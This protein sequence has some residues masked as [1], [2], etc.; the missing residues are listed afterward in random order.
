MSTKNYPTQV[1][2]PFGEALWAHL[3]EADK[4]FSELGDF[5]VN[6]KISEEDASAL[7]RQIQEEKE[8]A[9]ITFKEEAKSE[10]KTA[11][12]IDK[13]KL[14]DI[15]PYEEDDEEE[16]VYIFKFK[17]KAAYVKDSGEIMHF[18]VPLVDSTGKTIPDDKKPNIGN[19]S[20]IR[21]IAE[22]VPYHM[23]TSGVGIS[24]RL[25]KVQIKKLV[26]F[27][28]DGPGFDAIED[29]GYTPPGMDQ[30]FDGSTGDSGYSV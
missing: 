23:A 12:A 1:T 28:S 22:L 29:G 15:D 26:E 16:G 3:K 30:D 27:S 9:L 8:K 21:V 7:I 14:S 13:I 5:K 6:L 17:R 25:K 18:D 19:G 4:K 20:V 11:K 2:T 10:G 24:L